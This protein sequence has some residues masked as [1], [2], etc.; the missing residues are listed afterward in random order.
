MIPAIDGS[1]RPH[2]CDLRRPYLVGTAIYERRDRQAQ[3]GVLRDQFAAHVRPEM[4]W[5]R[6][7]FSRSSSSVSLP[8]VSLSFPFTFVAHAFH[9]DPFRLG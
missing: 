7:C 4:F 2:R 5:A 6:P 1:R 3:L 8:S 9:A